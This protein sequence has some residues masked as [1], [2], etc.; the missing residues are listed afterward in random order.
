MRTKNCTVYLS[1][2]RYWSG[3]KIF[4]M[5]YYN[6]NFDEL[7]GVSPFRTGES[8]Y[9]DEVN[10][11]ASELDPNGRERIFILDDGFHLTEK[12]VDIVFY[13]IGCF[14][15]LEDLNLLTPKE[16]KEILDHNPYYRAEIHGY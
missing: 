12:E 13:R 3:F 15:S 9:M 11:F 10:F 14:D 1:Q 8:L 2:L 4:T 16:I 7:N 6:V 5:W